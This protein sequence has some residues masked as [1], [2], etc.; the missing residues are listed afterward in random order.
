MNLIFKM[1]RIRRYKKNLLHICIH[2]S[3]IHCRKSNFDSCKTYQ[4][5]LQIRA[6][7]KNNN[8]NNNSNY[9]LKTMLL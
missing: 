5:L 7:V 1:L 4:N 8:D 6:P 3:G 9:Y 2:I